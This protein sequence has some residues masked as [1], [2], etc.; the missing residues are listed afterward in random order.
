MQEVTKMDKWLEQW[1][2]ETME[3]LDLEKEE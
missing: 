1:L 3:K 2:N